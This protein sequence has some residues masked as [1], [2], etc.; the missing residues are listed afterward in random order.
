MPGEGFR[1]IKGRRPRFAGEKVPPFH[2]RRKGTSQ[3]SFDKIEHGPQILAEKIYC[4][5]CPV[6][7]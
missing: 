2:L 6:N 7:L 1:F 5:L 3:L 4:D